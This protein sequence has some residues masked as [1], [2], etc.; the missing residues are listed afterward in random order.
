[1]LCFIFSLSLSLCAPKISVLM[2]LKSLKVLQGS[3]AVKS[4][5]VFSLKREMTETVCQGSFGWAPVQTVSYVINN[6]LKSIPNCKVE[7]PKLI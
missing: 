6:T 3:S 1:M 4:A 5:L 7:P 2:L